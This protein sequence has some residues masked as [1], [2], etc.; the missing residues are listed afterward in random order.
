MVDVFYILQGELNLFFFFLY[1]GLI[2]EKR[3]ARSCDVVDQLIGV[4]QC[5]TPNR[6]AAKF[7]MDEKE[8]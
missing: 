7:V 2:L 6:V 5:A 4:P 8:K 1:L 3:E